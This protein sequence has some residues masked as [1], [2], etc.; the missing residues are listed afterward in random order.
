MTRVLPAS[1]A[2]R[3]ARKKEWSVRLSNGPAL[4][5]LAPLVVAAILF[6][7]YP[8]AMLL[9]DSV[10]KGDGGL[11][12]YIAAFSSRAI[13]N[14]FLM[15]IFVSL[16]VTGACLIMGSSVA[17]TMSRARRPVVRT[18]LWAGV[19]LPFWMGLVVQTYALAI[20]I[21]RNGP[22]NSL[23]LELGVIN[24]PTRILYTPLAIVIGM[25]FTML[26]YGILTLYPTMQSFDGELLNAAES[27]GTSRVGA[28]RNIWLPTVLPGLVASSAVV[29]AMCLGF[30]VTPV[31]LGGAQVPFIASAISDDIFKFYNYP[32]AAAVS[33]IL[34]LIAAVTVTVALRFVGAKAFKGLTT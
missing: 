18:A 10:T 8:L 4:L 19:L 13:L 3:G 24:E 22:I 2:D 14:S 27:L 23:L 16:V 29:F 28:M 30:F 17:W 11:E 5:L 6:I 9:I 21:A 7:I 33:V 15:T 25:T 20:M 1:E 31:L 26:P 12:N 32:R 34:L